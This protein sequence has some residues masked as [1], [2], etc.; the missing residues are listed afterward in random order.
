L[1]RNAFVPGERRS[2]YV[3]WNILNSASDQESRPSDLD[4]Q[5]VCGAALC[6]GTEGEDVLASKITLHVVKYGRIVARRRRIFSSASC[7]GK[8]RKLVGAFIL[9]RI[10]ITYRVDNRSG[11][12]DGI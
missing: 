5:A 2:F 6:I 11:A 8:A 9:T 7:G 4:T 3:G 1:G 12:L 10:G